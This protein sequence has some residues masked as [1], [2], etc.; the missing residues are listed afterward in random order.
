MTLVMFEVND[1]LTE[2]EK[3]NLTEVRKIV[4]LRKEHS[5]L[6]YGNY[7]TILA[8]KDIFAY[9]RTDMNERLF[10]ILNKGNKPQKVSF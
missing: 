3:N 10:I 9:V 2:D 1:E 6:R 7:Y 4:N 5:A 8:G